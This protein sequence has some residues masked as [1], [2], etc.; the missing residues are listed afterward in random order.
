MF[1]TAAPVI[2]FGGVVGVNHGAHGAIEK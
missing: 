2:V 1:E